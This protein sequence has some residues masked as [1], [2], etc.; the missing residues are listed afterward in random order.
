MGFRGDMT[1]S[2]TGRGYFAL[3]LTCI[4]IYPVQPA[5]S[6]WAANNLA[7]SSRRTIGVAFNI[8]VGNIEGIIGPYI[9]LDKE[10]PR[11][12]TRFGLSLALPRLTEDDIRSR[13]TEEQLL[14]LGDK[15]SLFKYTL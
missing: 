2:H 9:Y 14:K 8:C 6:I 10:A 15:S 13:Y 7:P 4:D 3:V 12:G 1:G 11:Y 5:G